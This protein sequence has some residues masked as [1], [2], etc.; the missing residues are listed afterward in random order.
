MIGKQALWL[1]LTGL[2]AWASEEAAHGGGHG[3]GDPM[4]VPKIVN[5][6]I[7]AVGIGFL[8]IKVLFPALKDKQRAILDSLG[9]ASK[10]ADEAKA[11][12]AEVDKRISGL[13]AEIDSLRVQAR[14]EMEQ[15]SVRFSEETKAM[16]AKV[17]Q[18]A[19]LEMTSAVKAAKQE[20]RGYAADLAVGLAY[21]KIEARMDD[22]AQSALVD[23]FVKGLK[24]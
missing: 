21:K 7:F 13:Q 4:L 1:I 11:K 12:A 23:R 17:E 10:R 5:F 20:L 8:L 18:S 16:L 9:A 2:S 15:E 19:E 3:G 22:A 24:N 6:A 14:S